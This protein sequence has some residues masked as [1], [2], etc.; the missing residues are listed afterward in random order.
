[1]TISICEATI[2]LPR[3][4]PGN[5]SL[6]KVL[7]EHSEHSRK[8]WLLTVRLCNSTYARHAGLS[9]CPPRLRIARKRQLVLK[10]SRQSHA[11][12]CP[13][14]GSPSWPRM[15][16]YNL[17]QEQRGRPPKGEVLADRVGWQT[18]LP[19]WKSTLSTSPEC[20]A[21]VGTP[22][23]APPPQSQRKEMEIMTWRSSTNKPFIS[24]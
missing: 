20:P 4:P 6:C 14:G 1:M 21:G 19:G 8:A 3:Y 7:S 18:D 22:P 5:S 24:P 10:R 13:G 9:F 15:A 23:P 16:P 17:Q 11:A 12:N 2:T